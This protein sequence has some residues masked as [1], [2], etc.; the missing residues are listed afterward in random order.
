MSSVDKN[1]D[2][3]PTMRDL[4]ALF[5]DKPSEKDIEAIK[6][7]ISSY[8]EE[9]N[10]KIAAIESNVNNITES[11]HINSGRIETLENESLKQDKLRNNICFSGMPDGWGGNSN[12]LVLKIAKILNASISSNDFT[13]YTTSRNS[14]VIASFH[15]YAH[16]QTLLHKMR[17]KKSIMAE[18]AYTPIHR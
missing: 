2:R 17:I 14:F 8:K 9:Q 4:I 18:E 3:Q 15:N 7:Q 12:E 16:K 5:S 11:T 13:A 6:D 1:L 10:E